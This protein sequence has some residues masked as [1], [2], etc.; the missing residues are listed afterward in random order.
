MAGP[1]EVIHSPP[2][3]IDESEAEA[4]WLQTHSVVVRF[5]LLFGPYLG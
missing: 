1:Q 4:K 3:Q 5:G 2:E